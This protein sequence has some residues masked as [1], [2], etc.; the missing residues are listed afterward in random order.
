MQ[1][2]PS[3]RL[4]ALA[5]LGLSALLLTACQPPEPE[6]PLD[7]PVKTAADVLARFEA[8]VKACASL[9]RVLESDRTFVESFQSAKVRS[10][11]PVDALLR[12]S[13]VARSPEVAY[14]LNHGKYMELGVDFHGDPWAVAWVNN[15]PIFCALTFERLSEVEAMGESGEAW[16]IRLFFLDKALE[17]LS[18]PWDEGAGTMVEFDHF[19]TYVLEAS[20][21]YKGAQQAAFHAWLDKAIKTLDA[22]RKGTEE[23]AA[24]LTSQQ[25]HQMLDERIAFLRQLAQPAK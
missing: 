1:T 5:L 23:G 12:K 14:F 15:E 9:V 6:V 16:R 18:P 25:Q 3:L 13:A 8:D 10:S 7:N 24:G 11:Q 19:K 2:L 4:A 17:N 22:S 20:R 21:I